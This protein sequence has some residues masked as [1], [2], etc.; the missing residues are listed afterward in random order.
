[1]K[2]SSLLR[3]TNSLVIGIIELGNSLVISL[4][5]DGMESHHSRMYGTVQRAK[6][7]GNCSEYMNCMWVRIEMWKN[8]ISR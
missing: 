8:K 4:G 7:M 1:M 3:L 5:V 2:T 6:Q